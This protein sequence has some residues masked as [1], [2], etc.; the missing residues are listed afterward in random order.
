MVY[1]LTYTGCNV[2]RL[3]P[4]DGPEFVHSCDEASQIFKRQ[5]N[6]E[7]CCVLYRSNA[8]VDPRQF[9]LMSRI[10]RSYK[11][12]KFH[13]FCFSFK[14]NKFCDFSLNSI[15]YTKIC[16]LNDFSV[17]CTEI[18]NFMLIHQQAP[19]WRFYKIFKIY[20]FSLTSR[21]FNKPL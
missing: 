17:R 20:D 4:R 16:C 3:R 13:D 9:A 14:F 5:Q 12:C 10:E 21:F 11:F 6:S 19:A 1:R 15:R 7:H 18:Y 8:K 2:C